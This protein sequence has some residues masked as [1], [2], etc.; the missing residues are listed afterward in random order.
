VPPLTENF[1]V[2]NHNCAHKWV[3]VYGATA[4][5]SKLYGALKVVK[6]V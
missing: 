4:I 1:P 3:G 6:V 2:A 5:P